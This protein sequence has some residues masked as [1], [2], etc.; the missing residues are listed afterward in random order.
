M[1]LEVEYLFTTLFSGTNFYIY[2]LPE[3]LGMRKTLTHGVFTD[4][5]GVM[6]VQSL[7]CSPLPTEISSMMSLTPKSF[8]K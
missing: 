5:H 3:G 4:F 1:K 6:K 2:Q 7:T 8:I